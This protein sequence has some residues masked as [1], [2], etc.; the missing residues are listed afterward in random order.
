MDKR[1][2]TLAC[3]S[4][5]SSNVTMEGAEHTAPMVTCEDCG[6]Q[7]D[8]RWDTTIASTRVAL[9]RRKTFAEEV[10]Q[11]D[12]GR[13]VRNG[14]DLYVVQ[15]GGFVRR[16]RYVYPMGA[17]PITIGPQRDPGT[18]TWSSDAVILFP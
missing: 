11:L 16:I 1:S 2:Y 6:T 4:C 17:D 13:I 15:E 14:P 12:P 3:V 8:I 5:G 9:V 10:R 18:V 7:H